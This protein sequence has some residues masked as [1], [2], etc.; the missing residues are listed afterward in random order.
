MLVLLA[1]GELLEILVGQEGVFGDFG[2]VEKLVLEV[3]LKVLDPVVDR[4]FLLSELVDL[5]FNLLEFLLELRVVGGSHPF[6]FVLRNLFD[7]PDSLED[8]GDVVDAALLHAEGG[9][10]V[11]EVE[12]EFV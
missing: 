4:F 8:V 10:R 7:V 11:V 3:V 2:V 6:D 1:V 9:D 12:G 5:V